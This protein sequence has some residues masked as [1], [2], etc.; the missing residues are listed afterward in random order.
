M[1]KRPI[2]QKSNKRIN[3]IREDES[4]FNKSLVIK[5]GKTMFKKLFLTVG[6][7]FCVTSFSFAAFTSTA[8][9]KFAL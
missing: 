8:G 1:T 5:E 7:L 2:L 6:I 9:C 4:M 3:K